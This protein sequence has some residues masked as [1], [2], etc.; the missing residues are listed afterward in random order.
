M[1]PV[2]DKMTAGTSV[3]RLTVPAVLASSNVLQAIAYPV[4]SDVTLILIV[5]TPLTKWVVLNPTAAI[6]EVMFAL[7]YFFILC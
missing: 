7:C 3:M 2:M 6:S 1:L 4:A 5:R